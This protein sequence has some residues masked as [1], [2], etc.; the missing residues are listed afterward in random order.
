MQAETTPIV[1]AVLN[2]LMFQVRIEH[3]ARHAGRK[4]LFVKS[5]P[6]ALA[7]ANELPA[8]IILDL[9]YSEAQP[10][11]LIDRLRANERTRSV[12]LLGYVSHVQTDLRR[13]A[14]EH[15]CN[16]VVARSKFVDSL[17]ELLSASGEFGV[18]TDP[19]S[20]AK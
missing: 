17:P 2:D 16:L 14:V 1:V 19:A 3:A 18:G 10:L 7:L 20:S 12:P 15:G 6:E 9:N 4:V 13:E 8:L 5:Q 11:E